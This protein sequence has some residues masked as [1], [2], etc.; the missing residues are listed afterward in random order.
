[1]HSGN[2]A[3][4]VSKAKLSDREVGGLEGGGERQE[5]LG[6]IFPGESQDTT[7]AISVSSAR[8]EKRRSRRGGAGGYEKEER[9]LRL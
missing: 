6:L 1:M 8:R 4:S 2:T 7:L 5:R 3:R 9:K